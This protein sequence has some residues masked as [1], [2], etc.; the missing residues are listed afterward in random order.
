MEQKF[1]HISGSGKAS[2]VDVSQKRPSKRRASASC[3]V[4][5]TAPREALSVTSD[6]VD[7]VLAA[8]LAGIMAAKR[9]SDIIPLCHP[10]GLGTIEIELAWVEQGVEISSTIA[11]VDRTGVEM[12]ALT[13]CAIAALSVMESIVDVDPSVRMDDLV[14]LAKSGGKSGPWGRLV[15]PLSSSNQ[16]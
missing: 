5:T 9:T 14:L 1:T 7:P 13:A 15:D 8:K 10:L 3:L 6:G 16:P 12:E 2:M 11:A 4:R